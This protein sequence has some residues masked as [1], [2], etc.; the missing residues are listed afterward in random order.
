MVAAYKG[1]LRIVKYL[2]TVGCA[3]ETRSKV[4]D[5][6]NALHLAAEYGH[7]QIT[8][9]LIKEGGISP[10]NVTYQDETP[11]Q[12]AAENNIQDSTEKRQEKDEIM[13]YLKTV[14]L[15]EKQ[16]VRSKVPQQQ[17]LLQVQK[18]PKE[19]ILIFSDKE[20]KGLLMSGAYRC[21]WNRI[22]LTGPFGVGKTSLAKLLVGDE[23]QEERESTD[24]IWIYLGRAG[25]DIK[26]RCWI[27]LKH[28][29]I[30]NATV[31]SLLRS[32][33]VAATEGAVKLVDDKEEPG[34]V[35]QSKDKKNQ[36]DVTPIPDAGAVKHSG[37]LSKP[38]AL[39]YQDNVQQAV[40]KRSKFKAFLDL[41]NRIQKAF[42]GKTPSH[43]ETSDGISAK[44]DEAKREEHAATIDMSEEE[45]LKLVRSQC[46]LGQY[47]MVIVPIDLW[48][49]GGQKIYHMTHQLFITSRGTFLLIFNGSRGVHQDI[50]DYTELPGCQGQRNTAV[51][52]IHWVNSVLTYC[53]TFVNNAYPKIV[54]VAT[55]KDLVKGDVEEQRTSL[56][57]SIEEL[58]QNH[59]GKNHLQYKPLI[60]VNAR[61]KEDKEIATLKKLLVDVALDHPRCGELMPTK[62]VPLE[63]QLAR[64]VEKNKKIL[65][66]DELNDMNKQNDKMALTPAQL[67]SFLKVNHALGKL[68]YFDEACLKDNVII[69]PV[70][71]VDVL[72][73]IVTDDQFWPDHLKEMLKAL[74]ESGRLLKKDLY[75]IWKQ[76][77]FREIWAHNDYIVD[78]LVHLDIICRQKDDEDGSDFFLVP[79]MISNKREESQQIDHDRSIHLA[80]R[81]KEEVVPPAI[82]YRFIATFISI[83]K[84]RVSAKSNRLMI[85]TDSADVQIDG[86]HDMRFDI[87]GNR[88]I[89]T[90]S[91]KEKKI[92]IIP[93][94]AST[95]QECLTHAI[96]NISNFYFSLS[97]DSTCNR[98]LPFTIQI[99]IPCGT[100][101]C[102]F[103]HTLSSKKEWKCP[104]HNIKHNTNIVSIWFADK[105]PTKD[106]RCPRDCSGL[107]KVW[108]DRQPEDKHL[109]R[110]A[111]KLTHEDTRTIYMLIKEKEPALQLDIINES[112]K[113]EG[114]HIKLNAL[115]D[116]KKSSKY[117][118]FKQLQNSLE[119]AKIDI[120][121]LCQISREFQKE[122]DQPRDMLRFRPSGS[123][124]Q[125]LPDH[126]G[127]QTFQLGIELGLSVV[128][129][130]KIES[131]HVTNLHG[132]TEEVLK[133][134]IKIPEATFEV[135]GKALHRLEL[136]SVLSSLTYD[137]E[138]GGQMDIEIDRHVR[139]RIIQDIQISQIL[140]YMMTHLV[141]SSDDRRRIVHHAGQD[142]QNKALLCEVIKRGEPTYTVFIDAL[143]TSG[144]PDLANE[145]KSD[146]QEEG[147]SAAIVQTGNIENKGL[148]NWIVPMYK[149]RL[150][151]NYSNIIDSIQHEQIVDHL[152]SRDVLTIAESQMIN[153]CPAQI[154]KNRK[155]MDIL[156]HGSEHVFIEFLKALRKDS[157]YAE[158]ADKIENTTVA[159]RDISTINGCFK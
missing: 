46:T 130:Q 108:L 25:M 129:M 146:G 134:W 91:N 53:K 71:L 61:N 153:A 125:Q 117:A 116:W 140:D 103:D 19:D 99:G 98:D 157:V 16:K 67:K 54:C 132:Q 138:L 17:G 47:E 78:M 27:F 38:G 139:E 106:D 22:F 114:F 41:P 15:T 36:D 119:E 33:E 154:Q 66:M 44:M 94:I 97:E 77:C 4:L 76:D 128:E 11:Y 135:L 70:F 6:K 136:S 137:E 100:D 120:H 90:L 3:R 43:F 49:F 96:T 142:D 121:K 143:R 82:L 26:E 148:S 12:L 48:D 102:F 14:M 92:S 10:L 20:F 158:L 152:I 7:L 105:L 87:Q 30:L 111:S 37:N 149:V 150:Q 101:L 28:G 89:V 68:I 80:Y 131:N 75:E 159:S 141:I 79:C 55:H 133:R 93:S 23:A 21:F 112:N 51:Y 50:P 147:S 65:T 31:Q 151:K 8:E 115:Y 69:D 9:W 62:F 126:I 24:G 144:Y 34:T 155:L 58:F 42:K 110:L 123:N 2:L 95:A 56:E 118:S 1:H 83:W 64:K 5:G 85:F 40:K 18:G 74:K 63:L 127:S 88:F 113:R 109:G 35:K 29:T 81:F 156:L 32:K 72:R 45:I 84:L 13:D 122:L 60:F 86:D 39:E 104:D 145:L 124:V 107:D 59:G 52:L 73:S 57:N